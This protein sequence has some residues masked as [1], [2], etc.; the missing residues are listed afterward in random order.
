[1]NYP[2]CQT[3]R[4]K[5]GNFTRVIFFFADAETILMQLDLNCHFYILLLLVLLLV[6]RKKI[7]E[8]DSYGF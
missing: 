1:M 8:I 5:T 7:W 2:T 3:P 4:R 6:R